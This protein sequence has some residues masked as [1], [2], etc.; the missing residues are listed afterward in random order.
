[1][2]SFTDESKPSEKAI[3]VLR[4]NA[5]LLIPSIGISPKLEE[6]QQ[7]ITQVADFV[8]QVMLGVS[9]WNKDWN[10]VNKN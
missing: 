5:I 7:S 2:N 10:K 1:M 9:Q 3:P 6:I 4:T 8:L